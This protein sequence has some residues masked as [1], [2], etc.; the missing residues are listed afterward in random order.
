MALVAAVLLALAVLS[1]GVTDRGRSERL[2]AS[3]EARAALGPSLPSLPGLETLRGAG[4]HAGD[5]EGGDAAGGAESD[6]EAQGAA[7]DEGFVRATD[8]ELR[9]RFPRPPPLPDLSARPGEVWVIPIEGT[10][11][12]GL[13]PFVERALDEAKDAAVVILDVNTFGGRVDAAV[14]IRDAL[15]TATVPTVA[16]VDRRAISAGALISLAANYLVFE[17]GGTLGAATPIQLGEGGEAKPV[18]E[19][20][21]SYMRSEMRST[22]EARGRSGELAE[23]MVDADVAVPGVTP[24][25]KLLT[26]TTELAEATGLANAVVPDM[27]AL[28]RALGLADRPIHHAE[29]NWA[30]RF[31]RFITDP[32]VSGILMSLG[33]LAL[34]IELYTP[35]FG[36]AGGI[37]VLFLALY[38]GGHLI[39][40]LA[41]W[42]EL[43][44]VGLGLVL[45][46]LE[47][48][49]IPGFGVT[50][51]LGIGFLVAGLALT[52]F[53]MPLNVAWESGAF[54]SALTVVL[55][56]LL[57]CFA[58]FPLAVWLLRLTGRLPKPT[59]G[60]W[61]VL[62]RTMAD[63]HSGHV[64]DA[65]SG[66]GGRVAVGGTGVALTALRPAGKAE[67]AG[68]LL[69]VVS[70]HGWVEKGTPIRVAR[71]EGVRIVVTKVKT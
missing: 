59:G 6:S 11:E 51:V 26:V 18:G 46:A 22:A 15:L 66:E 3:A 50:G 71:V 61:L 54:S 56:A 24:R 2:G 70:E 38:L 68:E 19:K 27:P 34:M 21:V 45:L 30:E 1:C 69:D 7:P 29:I 8:A 42:E 28:I 12:L 23:A 14:E 33:M 39:V 35:G 64:P 44:L 36:V 40:G 67:V 53:G 55:A 37:G 4:G 65:P 48:F 47:I 25:G 43:L 5:G 52:M 41:G 20:M 62:Q 13:A 10:I 58:T 31:V 60:P 63:S 49:V 32:T 9:A 17:P 57:G 16:F